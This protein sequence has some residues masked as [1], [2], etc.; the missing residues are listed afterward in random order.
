MADLTVEARQIPGCSAVLLSCHGVADAHTFER[1]DQAITDAF[2]TG[3]VNVI[4]DLSDVSYMSSAGL[5]ILIKSQSEAD[6]AGGAFLLLCPSPQVKELIE[7]TGMLDF[8]VVANSPQEAIKK[9]G[10]GG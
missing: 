3:A 8:F 6:E 7:T 5:G 1:L 4:A 9:L 10:V 2:G